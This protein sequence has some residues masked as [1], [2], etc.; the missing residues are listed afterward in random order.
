[1]LLRQEQECLGRGDDDGRYKKIKGAT[2]IA[3][4]MLPV[5]GEFLYRSAAFEFL[6]WTDRREIANLMI[7]SS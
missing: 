7:K 5:T 4:E 1:V 3:V 2:I 6:S